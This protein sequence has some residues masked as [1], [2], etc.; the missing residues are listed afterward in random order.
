M[1]VLFINLCTDAHSFF[2]IKRYIQSTKL[3]TVNL[4][5]PSERNKMRMQ[6]DSFTK[7]CVVSGQRTGWKDTWI[8]V[9]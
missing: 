8:R 7:C 2:K 5:S 3:I 9:L 4:P 1:T 6:N